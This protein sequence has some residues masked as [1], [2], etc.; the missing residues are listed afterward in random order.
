MKLVTYNIQYSLGKDGSYNLARIVEA[1][2]DADVIAL[3]EVTRNFIPSENPE[4]PEIIAKLLPNYYWVYGPQV[5]LDVSIRKED[6]MVINKRMQ[7]GNMLLARW[8]ILSSRLILLPKM[9]TYDKHNAQ[10][11]ALEGVVDLPGGAFRF[12]S[13]HLNYLSGAER[14]AQIEYLLPLLINM[15]QEGGVVSGPG[16]RE[17]KEVP[18]SHDFV[19]LGDFNLAPD[20]PEYI[21][22]VGEPDYYYGHRIVPQHLV[23]M[24]VQTGHSQ[25][26]GITWY[27]SSKNFE[28]GLRIDYGFVS[29]GLAKKVKRAWID[30][31]APGSDH[32]PTWFELD[33]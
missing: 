32:Q 19:L 10:F 29:A 24:W 1:V 3:Q 23:D 20:A 6:G 11:G 26:E 18:V 22:I 8:P 15:P 9:R 16:W 28:S 4:Q 5:D 21:R 2:K 14:M 30:E 7:F 13:I 25:E 17:F 27:D 33:L 31:K 12:Y